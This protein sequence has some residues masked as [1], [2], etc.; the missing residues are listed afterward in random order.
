VSRGRFAGGDV[1]LLKPDTYMNLSGEALRPYLRD[2]RFVAADDLLVVVDDAALPVGRFRLRATGSAGGHNGLKSIEGAV[3]SERYARI[4]IGV[5]PP[6]DRERAGD[7]ADFVL[8]RMGKG[9]RA[10]VEA[11][12]PDLVGAIET[13]VNEGVDLAMTRYNRRPK[14]P[15]DP[16][17]LT[18]EG[19]DEDS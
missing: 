14:K 16:E 9:E 12:Y 4:R 18:G 11:L 7:L 17:P 2:E 1:R 6:A 13:W 15:A 5:G 10:E 3:G 19:G 8:D